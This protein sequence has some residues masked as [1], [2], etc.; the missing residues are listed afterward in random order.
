MAIN[1][2]EKYA[3]EI[4]TVFTRESLI[5][6]RLSDNFDFS[7]VK[8]VNVVTPITVPMV[9]Y[10][11]GGV[12]RYGTP[13]EMED[14]VQEMTLTQDKSFS[15]TIDKG[16]DADTN[17]VKAAGKML[18]L[19]IAEQAVPLMDTYCLNKLAHNAGVITQGEA[20]TRENVCSRITAGTTALDNAEV[21]AD[22]RTLYITAEG[23][24]LL[25]KSDEFMR[26]DALLNQSLTK[27]QVGTYDGMAVVKVPESRWP[28]NVNFIIVHKSAACAPVKLNDTKL[29]NDPPGISGNLLE[30][31]Q[32]YDLFVLG[33]R[34]K[35]IFVDVDDDATLVEAPVIGDDG[36]ITCA[37]AGAKI[38]Y[39]TDGSDPRYSKS[40]IEGSTAPMASVVKACAYLEGAFPSGVTTVSK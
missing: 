22:D 40:A 32:Y 26:C 25:R 15:M 10:T 34:A 7:G 3:K 21:P 24:A 13:I 16:N 20:L 29:H 11:R 30:G 17:G 36:K 1:L 2:H 18:S 5:A 23:Y 37:T 8:T 28:K 27:G 19:Q 14:V 38:K 33:A 4:S 12:N 31:R 39:T 35:G 9:D 6:G